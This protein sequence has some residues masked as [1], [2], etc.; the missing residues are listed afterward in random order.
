MR[1][2]NFDQHITIRFS[3]TTQ[4]AIHLTFRGIC[5]LCKFLSSDSMIPIA[6]R[7]IQRIDA[8]MKL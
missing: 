8:I 6:S 4:P 7:I 2:C 1:N 3:N 5:Q